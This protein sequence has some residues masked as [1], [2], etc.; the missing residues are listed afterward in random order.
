MTLREQID[1]LRPQQREVLGLLC[2]GQTAGHHPRTLAALARH[3]LIVMRKRVDAGSRGAFSY[4][5]PDVPVD[6]HLA[7]C[8]WAAEQP[9]LL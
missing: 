2:M 7:Y 3:G 6:V 4:V 9:E 5:E 1:Q 8:E